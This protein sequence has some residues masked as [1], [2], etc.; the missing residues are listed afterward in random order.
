MPVPLERISCVPAVADAED[1]VVLVK[2]Y[3]DIKQLARLLS[4]LTHSQPF[5]TIGFMRFRG[6]RLL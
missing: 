5:Y 2:V 6:S 4:S 1:A 3:A